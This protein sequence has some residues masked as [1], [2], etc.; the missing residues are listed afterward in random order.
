MHRRFLPLALII[1]L[2]LGPMAAVAYA[3]GSD[4][5]SFN[6][7]KLGNQRLP[8]DSKNDRQYPATNKNGTVG[9]DAPGSSCDNYFKWQLVRNIS[10][11]PDE[12]VHSGGARFCNSATYKTLL[13]WKKAYYH[14]DVRVTD[15]PVPVSGNGFVVAKWP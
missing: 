8:S 10:L 12:V 1:F 2:G 9:Y 11:S 15:K 4:Y 5:H 14:F 6:A 3:A 7:A 13:T